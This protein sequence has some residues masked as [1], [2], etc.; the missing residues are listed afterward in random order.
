MPTFFLNTDSFKASNAFVATLNAAPGATY[1]AQINAVGLSTAANAMLDAMAATTAAGKATAIAANLGLTGAAATGAESYL[2]SVTFTGAASTWGAKL[3]AALDL[4][5]TLQNDATYGTAATA[6]VARVNTAVSYSSVAT[7]NSTDLST[8]ASAI[9]SSGS[10]GA[11]LTITLTD[12]A[13]NAVG[14]GGNDTISGVIIQASGTLTSSDTIDGAGGTDTFN[15]RI[16]DATAGQSVAPSISGIEILTFDNDEVAAGDGIVFNTGSASGITTINSSGSSAGSLTAVANVASAVAVGMTSTRGTLAIDNASTVYAGTADNVSVTLN[17]AGDTATGGTAAKLILDSTGG[18]SA[19]ANDTVDI[20]TIVTQTAA[21][22]VDLAGGSA[23]KT[24]T[25][26]G[27]VN[28]TLTDTEDSFG[29]V[30]SVSASSFTGAL[31]IDLS[32]NTRNVTFT[33]G[34]GDD[35]VRMGL[36]GTGLTAD[37][38]LD[39][40]SGTD[41]LAVTDSSFTAGDLAIIASDARTFETIELTSNI[42]SGTFDFADI[43]IISSL[44]FSGTNTGT[45]ASATTGSGAIGSTTLTITGVESGDSITFAASSTG[46]AGAATLASGVS[47]ATGI[48]SGNGGVAIALTAKVDDGS[49]SITLTLAGGVT[50]AG[51]AGGAAFT[52]LTTLGTSGNGGNAITASNFET[53]NI[54]STGT[55][56]NTIAGGAAGATGQAG[57]TIGSAGASIVVNTNGTI[58]VTGSRTLSLGTISGQNATVNAVDFTGALTVTGENGNNR[59]IGGSAADTINGGAGIDTLTGNGGADTFQFRIGSGNTDSESSLHRN[60]ATANSTAD[61]VVFA[62]DAITDYTKGS[63]LIAIRAVTT[64][65]AVT[66]AATNISTS[67]S[68]SAGVAAISSAG[69]ATFNAADDTLIERAIAVAMGIKTTTTDLYD[70]AFFELSGDS[71]VFVSDGTAGLNDGDLVIKL[72]GVTGLTSVSYSGGNLIFSS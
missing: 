7:N 22:R 50:I 54:V 66:M 46:G 60:N 58:N 11:G 32:S 3:L 51:G 4:F 38:T 37:D 35:V 52:G 21:S 24:L 18:A 29:S 57:D 40:G 30:T 27:N 53:V 23:V 33:G 47:G 41:R 36:I 25:I 72:T 26:S 61:A 63:D 16:T 13:N 65:D 12:A 20:V 6:Y 8:L 64:G 68:A 69:L 15:I 17:A 10:T 59:I 49:N 2:T 5:T 67:A 44:R 43:S 19:S 70:F 28:L 1:L 31:D 42:A 34:S 45:A 9:G 62:V 14:A 71:Y 56:T 39:A 48:A 55:S